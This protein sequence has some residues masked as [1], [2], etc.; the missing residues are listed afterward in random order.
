MS[1]CP[2]KS[3]SEWKQLVASRGEA[4]AYYLWYKNDGNISDLVKPK[5]STSNRVSVIKDFLN[6]I[7]V[8][9]EAVDTIIVDG[10]KQDATGVALIAQK[11]IQIVNGKEDVAL[12]EEAMHF[13]V[14]IIKQ[15]NPA[16]YKKLLSEINDYQTYKN[17][18]KTYG[19]RLDYQTPDGKPDILKLK[20]EAIAKVLANT[21]VNKAEGTEKLTENP[22]KSASMWQ[23]IK[24]FLRDLFSTSGFDE[25]SMGIIN[26]DFQGTV[27]D[28]RAN[29][30]S[31]FYQLDVKNAIDEAYDKVVAVDKD[32][33]V[34]KDSPDYNPKTG[35]GKKRHYLYKGQEVATSVTTMISDGDRFEGRSVEDKAQDTDKML[36]GSE[37]HN[38]IE[39]YTKKNLIDENGYIL[40]EFKDNPITTQLN[41]SVQQVLKKYTRDL[42]LGYKLADAQRTDGAKTRILVEVMVVNT[43]KKGMVAS[44]IDFM[45]FVPDD[46]TGVKVD[47]LDWKFTNIDKSK[48]QD[49]PW[50]KRGKWNDQMKEYTLMYLTDLY[51][52][53]SKQMGKSRMIP[54]TANYIYVNPQDK[55]NSRL[56]LGSIEAGDADS[57]QE[58][59]IYLLAVPTEAE[60]TGNVQIDELLAALRIQ[61]DK[62][63]QSSPIGEKQQVEKSLQLNQL[64]IAIRSLHVRLDFAPLAMSGANYINDVSGILKNF[65]GIDYEKLTADEINSKLQEL[66]GYENAISKYTRL[67][68]I[69]LSKFDEEELDADSQ[70]ELNKLRGL[71]RE[72]YDVLRK[73]KRL[74]DDYTVYLAL[75]MDVVAEDE[76]E[77]VLQAEREIP[78]LVKSFLEAS[79]LGSVIIRLS[80]N[81]IMRARSLSRIKANRV[82]NEFTKL[83]NSVEEEAKR[84]GKTAFDLIGTA[85]GGNLRLISEL[86]ADFWKQYD[87]AIT[88]KDKK[89]LL[90]NL[91]RDKYNELA[92]AYL[93]T[94]IEAITSKKFNDNPNID[95]LI[96]QSKIA[97]LRRSVDIENEEFNGFNDYNFKKFYLQTVNRDKWY[98]SDYSKLQQSPNALRL[99]EFMRSLNQKAKDMGY[100]SKKEKLSFF[101]LIEASFITKAAQS[102]N[103]AK[104]GMDFFKSMYQL[105]SEEEQKYSKLDPETNKLKRQ[106]P[107]F[108]TNKNKE[109]T[110]LSKDL[111][112]V[113]IMW[114][115]S[116]ME[117]ETSKDLET[118]LHILHKVEDS[119]G[120]LIADEN[121]RLVK[122]AHGV[123]KVDINNKKNAD[124]L[125]T[126]IDDH[127]YGLQENEDSWGNIQI[128][129]IATKVA[130]SDEEKQQT[131]KLNSKKILNTM[132]SYIQS[133]ALGLKATIALPNWF[134][135]NF[136]AYIN[137]GEFYSFKEFLNNNSKSTTGIGFTTIQKGLVDLFVPLNEDLAKEKIRHNAKDQSYTKWLE[138][139]NFNDVMMVSLSWPERKLQIA[140]ALS[141]I[142]NAGVIDGKIVNLRQYLAQQD[143]MNK[144]LISES[145]RK[146]L[147]NSFEK[148]L[149]DLKESV[150]LEK[151]AKFENDMIVIPGVSDDELAKFRVTMVEFGR[152][153]N[154]QMSA[155]NKADYT[156]DSMFK[157]FM[158]FK[159]WMP[160][161]ISLR[162]LD[163][164]KNAE[165][166]SWE[167]GRTRLMLK[168]I[169]HLGL[170]NITKMQAIINGTDEGLA[171]MKEMLDQ[172]KK[173]YFEKNG[174]ELKI[175]EAEFYDMVRSNLS[176]QMKELKML[177]ALIA[178]VIGAK[179]AAPDDDDDELTKNQYKF[180]AK[181]INKTSDE[182]S[183]YYNPLTFQSITNGS[184][185][186][187]LGVTN[188]AWN[189]LKTIS[190]D[191]YGYFTDDEKLMKDTHT[192]KAVLDVIPIL[193]QFQKE[194]LPSIDPELAKEMGIRVTAE[195]RQGR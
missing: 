9:V 189:V 12:P 165:L 78:G 77:D 26:G 134:G 117:Y 162:V 66:V 155:D 182:I 6:R 30:P 62:L 147:E 53:N 42:V 50:Y 104:E 96:K 61:Y 17:V 72:T 19:V 35:Q 3:L 148:R 191:S 65:E 45:A 55:K 137:G 33:E 114:I 129:K 38:F 125:K 174:K 158:M 159:N 164:Q 99:W 81:L 140:N 83:L 4:T 130:G 105:H 145:E 176:N 94:N 54:F 173:D 115:K 44:T 97:T 91:D 34:I 120:A 177:V 37:G 82:I 23:K 133:L 124:I 195:A 168:T 8:D 169:A 27:E 58:K 108:F 184:L 98:S 101:P 179:I 193:S 73:I 190:T 151:V 11:L 146:A 152:K 16:L 181:I 41:P 132:N 57:T 39:N 7:G 163:I 185:L 172:K 93:R 22:V 88:D 87:A 69:F 128:A 142:E 103:I 49:I 43:K 119:K 56:Y 192:L 90:D 131:L 153:L 161:Q 79:K 74:Y 80:S 46:V 85:E 109:V 171:I 1:T 71:T 138:T 36:W 156:R 76:K 64:A 31:V 110:K 150:T 32:M 86:S 51:G 13:A 122:D 2:N 170:R 29:F 178:L 59:D 180:F 20:D 95:D 63:Y 60:S 14:E 188:K 100:L 47:T 25:A 154:G 186:P 111:N 112:K 24:D 139:W 143:R 127:I 28:I 113:G 123:A 144:Y 175:T 126:M 107:I 187:A 116:L 75:K 70:I 183:F 149:E 106:I 160:K 84:S 166:G 68:D 167:Y 67:D 15:K 121:N 194:Y 40:D 141:F 21:L 89:F 135:Y 5:V 52:F 118:T 136:Q 92:K 18:V 157:S 10:V 48:D 102:G